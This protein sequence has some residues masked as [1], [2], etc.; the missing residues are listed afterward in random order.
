VEAD[1][2]HVPR[3][4]RAAALI[5]SLLV[6]GSATALVAGSSHHAWI[7]WFALVPLLLSIRILNPIQAMACGALWGASLFASAIWLVDASI[8][9]SAGSLLLL[10]VVPAT[11]A[12]VGAM[13]TRRV[14][15]NVFFLAYAWIGVEIALRP[16][17][18]HDG[19]LA[20]TTGQE[21]LW[22]VIASLV[23]YA[24]VAFAVAF[25]N[26]LLVSVLIRI[27]IRVSRPLPRTGTRRQFRRFFGRSLER[28]QMLWVA[29]R[30]TRAPPMST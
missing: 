9:A 28:V 22:H 13:V 15:F 4:A 7:A 25:I 1:G 8:S 2:A 11:Y 27:R 18:M 30:Q 17:A 12:L 6:A 10:T 14:G 26:G 16:L 20:C 3:R 29:S 5:V 21:S 24:W 23:G 19:L